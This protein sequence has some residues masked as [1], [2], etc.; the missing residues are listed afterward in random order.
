MRLG[1][2]NDNL[3]IFARYQTKISTGNSASHQKHCS[4]TLCI[5]RLPALT[6]VLP[7]SAPT[8]EWPGYGVLYTT[9][10][11]LNSDILL[12]IFHHYQLDN[13]R[14]FFHVNM[15]I[16]F[17]NGTPPLDLLAHLPPLPLIV[18]YQGEDADDDT[19]IIH[20]IQHCNCVL[21]IVYQ[22]PCLHLGRFVASMHESFPRLE[23]ISLSSTTKPEVLEI[24]PICI[25]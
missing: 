9:T 4:R 7:P 17:T 3:L 19:G 23:F 22:A 5:N 8:S 13:E 16:L 18:D 12:A 10:D 15:H 2:D 11:M 6:E 25:V 1:H 24:H 21:C 14:V 20:A